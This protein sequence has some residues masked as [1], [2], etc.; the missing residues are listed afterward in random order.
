[1][2]YTVDERIQK[3]ARE[4]AAALNDGAEA[5]WIDSGTKG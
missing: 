1:M 5:G 2:I 4:L 3:A